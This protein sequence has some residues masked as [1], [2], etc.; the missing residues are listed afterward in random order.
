MR[1][2]MVVLQSR[3]LAQHLRLSQTGEQFTLQQFIAHAA[4]EAFDVTIL[5]RTAWLDVQRAHLRDPQPRSDRAGD[6][7]RAIVRAN[8]LPFPADQEQLLEHIDHIAAR[9]RSPHLQRQALTRELIHDA[10]ELERPPILRPVMNKI[11]R[12]DMIRV[13]GAMM[14]DSVLTVAQSTLLMPFYRHFQPFPPPQVIHPLAIDLESLGSQQGPDKTIAVAR[15]L[16]DQ[17]QHPLDQ[18]RLAFASLRLIAL[19]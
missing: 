17:L 3:L 14:H 12:P 10:Q 1:T 9:K 5:P 8:M 6:E 4:V 18:F 7:L 19:R 16:P 15:M 2:A 13:R 11:P